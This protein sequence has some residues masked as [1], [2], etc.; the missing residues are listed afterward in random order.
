MGA[1]LSAP[2]FN[3][4]DFLQKGGGACC[5]KTGVIANTNI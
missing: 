1:E 5:L 2:I 3:I 4:E